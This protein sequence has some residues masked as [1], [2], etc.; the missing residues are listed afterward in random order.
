MQDRPYLEISVYLHSGKSAQEECQRLGCYFCDA[1]I[2]HRDTNLFAAAPL[3]VT[4]PTHVKRRSQS[5]Q[6]H[7]RTKRSGMLGSRPVV[8]QDAQK[9][10]RSWLCLYLVSAHTVKS[11]YRT[12]KPIGETT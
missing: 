6:Y 9:S 2:P 5:D 11:L 4:A 10:A 12:N 1:G 3:V 8:T 7:Y